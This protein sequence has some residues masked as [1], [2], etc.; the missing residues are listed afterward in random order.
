[1]QMI[2]TLLKYIICNDFL[3]VQDAQSNFDK[4]FVTR[5]IVK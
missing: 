3:N 5:K 1:M 2:D 4:K